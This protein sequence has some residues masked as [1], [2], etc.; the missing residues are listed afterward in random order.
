V[1]TPSSLDK[2]ENEKVVLG[3]RAEALGIQKFSKKISFRGNTRQRI[4]IDFQSIIKLKKQSTMEKPINPSIN[5]VLIDVISR[6][7]FF[8]GPPVILPPLSG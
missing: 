2:Q 1:N 8:G 3:F 4:G 5:T 6:E 7:S